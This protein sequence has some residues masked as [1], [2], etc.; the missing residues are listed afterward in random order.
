MP[1]TKVGSSMIDSMDASKLSGALPSLD[2]TNL[3]GLYESGE[4][5]MKGADDPQIDTNP[6]TVGKLWLNTTS[7][8]MYSCT[9]I[10]TGANVWKAVSSVGEIAP[11][12]TFMQGE[13]YGYSA[14]GENDSTG[15]D[16]HKTDFASDGDATDHGDL[17]S[18]SNATAGGSSATHGYI[19][20]GYAQG[21][22]S[23]AATRIDKFAFSSN[24][25]ATTVA[26][27]PTG[28]YNHAAHSSYHEDK[29]FITGGWP[30]GTQIVAWS[31][32]NDG[33]VSNVGSLAANGTNEHAGTASSTHG[34]LA[35]GNNNGISQISKFLFASGHTHTNVGNL[36]TYV[37]EM[38]A[39]TASDYGYTHAGHDGSWNNKDMIQKH[40]F[41]SDGDATSVGQLTEAKN[42]SGGFSSMTH[43]YCMGGKPASGGHTDRIEKYTFVS[44]GSANT[45]GVLMNQLQHIP[46]GFQ[47]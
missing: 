20:G 24:T 37:Q 36:H 19:A 45:V 8:K 31:H 29:T 23:N 6:T 3:T 26:H 21:V 11:F 9:D 27:L 12:F 38:G 47:V 34:Y 25:I 30:N 35:G 33:S 17:T 44:D 4:I 41:A 7:G 1:F 13:T 18:A 39:S 5:I 40:A 43:G 32:S 16:I 14:G 42:A 46:A 22:P 28:G 2:S 10:T 15:L